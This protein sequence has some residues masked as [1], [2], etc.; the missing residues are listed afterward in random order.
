MA[1]ALHYLKLKPNSEDSG[2]LAKATALLKSI[3][4]SIRYFNSSQYIN[5]LA[6][7]DICLVLGYSGDVLQA[8]KRAAEAGQGVKI[9]YA[10]PA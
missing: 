10:I 4:P 3:R 5:D 6:N 2:D 8:K 7:G 9:A 1:A